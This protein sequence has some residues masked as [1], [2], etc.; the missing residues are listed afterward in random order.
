MGRP[1]SKDASVP[2][3][4]KYS[5]HRATLILCAGVLAHT[6]TGVD[7]AGAASAIPTFTADSTSLWVPDRAAGDDFLPPKSGAGPVVSD[8][9]HAYKPLAQAQGQL[10]FRVADLDNPVLKPWAKEQMKKAND[11]VL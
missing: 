9:E 7:A 10:S 8:K 1:M 3:K 5:H 6:P 11:D 2:E 4:R